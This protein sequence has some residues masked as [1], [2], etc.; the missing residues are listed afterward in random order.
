MIGRWRDSGRLARVGG[1]DGLFSRGG[2]A[3]ATPVKELDI[4]T[5][6]R[7]ALAMVAAGREVL[8]AIAGVLFLLPSLALAVLVPEPQATPGMTPREMMAQLSEVYTTYAPLMLVVS[9]LQMAG[10]ITV[11]VTMTDRARPTV[12]QALRRGF[13]A[14]PRYLAA[15]L[16]IGL[17]FGIGL[18]ALGM[19]AGVSGNQGVA[20]ALLFFAAGAAVHLVLR[21]ALVA[22]VLAAEPR[23]GP[24][25]ALRRSW[26]LTRGHTLRLFAFLLLA[27]LLF[28]VLYG[29]IMLF[30]GLVLVLLTSGEVQRT[31]AALV[32][33]TVTATAMVY[34]SAMLA[35]VHG[36]LAGPWQGQI[37]GTFE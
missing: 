27:M 34:A 26:Q 1:R 17:G 6:W 37:V 4:S 13:F 24:I 15:Q 3:R 20:A 22:P 10:V 12:A 5:A 35:A 25:A 28:L 16:L 14:T 9:A 2:S 33:S 23:T 19:I 18:I 29:L 8:V 36:Q 11:I 30:V 32:S 7:N 31:L 21:L